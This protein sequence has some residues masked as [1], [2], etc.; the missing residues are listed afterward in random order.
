MQNMAVDVQSVELLRKTIDRY[1]KQRQVHEPVLRAFQP[2]LELRVALEESFVGQQFT[3]PAFDMERVNQG[4]PLLA[5]LSLAPIA[6]WIEQSA[7]AVL[8]QLEKSMPQNKD[9]SAL[10]QL[11]DS[12]EQ[13]DER[14]D[15]V[16]CCEAFLQ[17]DTSYL[18]NVADECSVDAGVLAFT[19]EQVLAPAVAALGR[20]IKSRFE[21]VSWRQGICPVCGSLPSI[22]YLARQEPT[23]L[24]S[25]VGGGGQKYLHCS[26]CGN[27]WRFRRDACPACDNADP[28][29]REIFHVQKAKQERIEACTKCKS[30][31][32][33]IDLREFAE[34]PHLLAAPLGLMHLDL[35][36]A[37][38]GFT[39]LA[40]APWNSGS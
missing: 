39:P 38:K 11:L 34:D 33:C 12:S 22:A 8:P 27:E 23:D 19:L 15:L 32:L 13:Q 9:F 6:P 20:K 26:L 3:L 31:F 30:Y 24:D 25:L 21:N 2:L 18:N 37:D 7:A 17:R 28:G 35:V 16:R 14:I 1:C 29:T 10:R 36:A 5:G 40:P 4:A